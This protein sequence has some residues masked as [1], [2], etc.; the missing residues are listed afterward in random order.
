MASDNFQGNIQTT[1]GGVFRTL[2]DSSSN[3]WPASVVCYAT[4]VSNGANVLVVV[5]P[6][7][8]LPVQ[9]ATSATWATNADE[10][11]GSTSA[12]TK[13]LIVGGKTADGTPA[14]DAL[15]LAAGGASVVVTGSGTFAVQS[16]A[17]PATTGGLTMYRLL[18]ANSDN[19]TN[20]KNG[21]GQVY[22][23]N[24]YNLGT[25]IAFLKLYNKV[26]TPVPGTDTPVKT[27]PIPPASASG[28]VGGV[29]IPPDA[30]GRAFS[31]GIGFVISANLADSD[32]TAV[33]AN[34]IVLNL[35]YN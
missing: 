20:L 6:S 11:A 5:Q 1:A 24:V 13:I 27:I 16:T 30:I 22:G 7:S 10:T 33:A 34:Q 2:S 35:E 28:Q 21:A 29:S 12:P 23:I 15:P 25:T 32:T 14:Y 8:G 26:S 4:T 17:K 9:P 19:A 18:S 3:Q 31:L